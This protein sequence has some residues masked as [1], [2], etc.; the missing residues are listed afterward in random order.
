LTN[1][2]HSFAMP[3]L[4]YDPYRVFAESASPAGLYARKKWLGQE[5]KRS[6]QDDFAKAVALLMKGQAPD[7]GWHNSFI[8]TA[9]RLFSLHLTVR[10]ANV[11]IRRGLDWL[12][13]RTSCA[14]DP[15]VALELSPVSGRDL[16]GLPFVPDD[17]R[18]LSLAMTLFLATIFGQGDAAP[19]VSQYENLSRR[20][21]SD[22]KDLH[23]RISNLLRAFAVHPLLAADGATVHIVERLAAFQDDRGMWPDK[24]AL[25][26]TVN[27]LAHLSL[28]QA[29]RQLD[30]AFRLLY[31]TQNPD[32]TWGE[33]GRE[34]N[35]FLVVHALRNKGVLIE[36]HTEVGR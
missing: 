10:E 5:G 27:A 21:V 31:E 2:S 34:W 30:R 3:P 28:A 11:E 17:P 25:Y 18:I 15:F 35:T 6:W 8:V 7:G 20:I 16:R 22:S 24:E 1:G 9:Q 12:L 26:Q 14:E 29:D 32:G 33:D 36:E 19:V 13:R 4:R 23:G